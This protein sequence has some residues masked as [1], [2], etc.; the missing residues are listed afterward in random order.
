MVTRRLPV[1]A[2]ALILIAI[3]G[4]LGSNLRY[5]LGAVAGEGL[6]VTILVNG[7]GSV[8]LGLLLFDVRADERLP[9]RVRYLFGTGFLASFTTYS[10]FIADTATIGG[11]S[12][13]AY[14]GA[15][16]AAGIG[17]I[18]L[19]R[20]LVETHSERGVAAVKPGDE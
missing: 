5:V 11:L 18:L 9:K 14:V 20:R 4:I 1:H 15:S 19:S 17:G 12:A 2:S 6:L 13:I 7:A 3:G 10:T 8:G 16:Y